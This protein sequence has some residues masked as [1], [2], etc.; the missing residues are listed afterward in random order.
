[1]AVERDYRWQTKFG[2]WLQTYGVT[3][4]SAELK[5]TKSAVYFWLRPTGRKVYPD[6]DTAMKICEISQ[7]T[8]KLE[9]IYTH[10][11]QAQALHAQNILRPQQAAAA[12]A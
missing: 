7:G 8:L 2:A 10:R 4:L 9:D 11:R 6:P 5:I 3:R 1:M 12:T